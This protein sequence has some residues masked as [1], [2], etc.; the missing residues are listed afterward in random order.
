V[1]NEVSLVQ[2]RTENEIEGSKEMASKKRKRNKQRNQMIL[3]LSVLALVILGIALIAMIKKDGGKE[4]KAGKDQITET[5]TTAEN[6]SQ[7]NGEGPAESGDTEQ[8]DSTSASEETTEGEITPTDETESTDAG[9]EAKEAET[10]ETDEPEEGEYPATADMNADGKTWTTFDGYTMGSVSGGTY[11]TVYTQEEISALSSEKKGYGQ[12]V[13]VD[14]DNRPVSALWMQRDYEKYGAIFIGAKADPGQE[15]IYLTTDEGYENGQTPMILD[16]LKEKNCK[17]V[18]FVT[19]EFAKGNPDLMKRI[20]DEGHV[21]GNHTVHHKSMPTL[22]LEEA[23][24][25]LT[26]LHNYVLENYGYEM[27]L[28]RP[29]MGEFSEQTLALAQ[30]LGYRTVLWSYAYRD[31]DIENQPDPTE[32][33]SKISAAKH[34][35]AIYLLH[36][37]SSTNAQIW[38]KV[39]DDFRDGG[40]EVKAIPR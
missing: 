12:G 18:F 32:A 9:D 25:E 17:A 8:A 20:I 5:V 24:N 37:V 13:Q 28:F 34:D 29:P 16:K 33:L 31:Y 15:Y 38:D 27:Y 35:G 26:E 40:Y 30:S 19:M 10:Q 2:S 11:G 23:S 7:A 6:A 39:I 36:A 1:Y 22:S 21:M 14:E 3:L 4:E